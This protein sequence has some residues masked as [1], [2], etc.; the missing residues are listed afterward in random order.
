MLA[1]A[2]HRLH[3]LAAGADLPLRHRAEQADG[4][5]DGRLRGAAFGGRR[6]RP[7]GREPAAG[8]TVPP[9]RRR[10][11][12]PT[13]CAGWRRCRPP[14]A[15]RWASAAAPFVLA[16]HT[17]PVLARR[18]LEAAMA[19]T[20]SACRRRASARRRPTARGRRALRPPRRA[21][22]RYSLLR[23]DV[24]QIGAGAPARAAAACWRATAC[25]R[26][27]RGWRSPEVG[28]GTGGNLLE[29]LRLGFAPE[30]PAPA[31]NCCPSALAQARRVLPAGAWR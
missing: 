8:L 19:A 31:S 28:C 17:Y 7:G 21:D 18:F 15:V 13:A 24:W 27:W 11:R 6:Q 29:L 16:H 30:Q 3:R 5:H 10:Q 2:R 20:T 26:R 1:R 4:L 14:S 12:S 22:E 25:D 9:E 23:P